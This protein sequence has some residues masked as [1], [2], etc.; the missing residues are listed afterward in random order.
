MRIG[1]REDLLLG[2]SVM[3]SAERRGRIIFLVIA[4]LIVAIKLIGVALAFSRGWEEVQWWKSVI[5]PLGFA[6]GIV[7]LWQGENWL[8]W[9]VSLALIVIGSAQLFVV[10]LDLSCGQ[11]D[12]SSRGGFLRADVRS[13]A[14]RGSRIWSLILECRLDLVVLAQRQGVLCLSAWHPDSSLDRE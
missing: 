11:E 6:L 4:T 1:S 3:S 9:I 8:R 13:A 14:G 2:G 5:Q 7:C 12:A 10:A